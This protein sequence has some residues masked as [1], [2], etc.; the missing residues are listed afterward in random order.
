MKTAFLT[1][2]S[3][4]LYFTA[5]SQAKESPDFRLNGTIDKSFN[6]YQIALKAYDDSKDIV[7]WGDT[8]IIADGKFYFEGPQ[9][10]LGSS[11]LRGAILAWPLYLN[12]KSYMK[13]I[14]ANSKL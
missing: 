2:F 9:N 10:L 4:L 14:P 5:F 7:V 13:N 12:L 6:G 3:S 1:L 11:G 8:T